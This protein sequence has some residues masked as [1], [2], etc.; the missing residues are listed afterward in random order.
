MM[1]GKMNSQNKGI[2]IAAINQSIAHKN[3]AI[4]GKKQEVKISAVISPVGK[5]Q[6][7]LQ[8]LMKQKQ[9]LT[10]RMNSLSASALEKGTDVKSTMEEYRKQLEA[11]NEQILKMQMEQEDKEDDEKTG[12]YKKPKTKA[13][14]EAQKMKDIMSLSSS[15]KQVEIVSSAKEQ[16]DGKA[17]VL[18]AEIK[19][20]NG[21]IKSKMEKVAELESKSA[22]LSSDIGKRLVD[23]NDGIADIQ[24]RTVEDEN[25]TEPSDTS[26]QTEAIKELRN[27]SDSTAT[28]KR[29]LLNSDKQVEGK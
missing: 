15:N 27:E 8:Q 28:D 12:V 2:S 3:E 23:V 22:N 21:N 26:Q 13:E 10:D 9:D 18:K 7:M 14:V 16:M 24:D 11:L 4:T 20:G 6:S 29:G 17:N 25:V 5:K 19:T 1:I